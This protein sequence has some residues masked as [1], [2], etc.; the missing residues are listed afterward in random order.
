MNKTSL[1]RNICLMGMVAVCLSAFAAKANKSVNITVDGTARSYW[2][3]V[4]D[5]CQ[6]SAP[7]VFALHGAR[8]HSPDKTPHFNPID[9]RE[10]VIVV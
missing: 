9:A 1:L 7:A 3:Y 2:L 8:G 4:P 5:N 6:K 10:G